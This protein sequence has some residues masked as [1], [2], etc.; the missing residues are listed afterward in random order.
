MLT[1]ITIKK[2]RIGPILFIDNILNTCTN[3]LDLHLESVKWSYSSQDRFEPVLLGLRDDS[4][5]WTNMSKKPLK[6]QKLT[7]KY[8]RI[9]HLVM[10]V[11][12]SRC[13]SLKSLAIASAY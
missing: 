5:F 10:E 12:F 11:L 4:D 7:V 1:T 8:W 9:S 3:L 6:L 2:Y 13:P